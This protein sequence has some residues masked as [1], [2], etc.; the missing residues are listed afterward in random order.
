MAYD[1]AYYE[2]YYKA[3]KEKII[4]KNKAYSLKYK[5]NITLK[6]RDLM[7][8]KQNNKC[9]ICNTK[10]SKVTPNIDHCH[11]TNKVRGLLCRLC[12]IGLGYFKDNTEILTKA[13]NYL[14]ETE[15][16]PEEL[17]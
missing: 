8:K 16:L 5:Y 4:T 6:E 10:F 2:A 14:K 15:T 13:I 1:K 7:L 17:K 9:K 11:T 3:N 12:N